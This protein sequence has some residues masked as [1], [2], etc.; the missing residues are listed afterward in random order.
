[1]ALDNVLSGSGIFIASS[2]FTGCGGQ[3]APPPL[4]GADHIIKMHWIIVL[5]NKIMIY[6]YFSHFIGG[7]IWL[8]H[9]VGN[10]NKNLNTVI[11]EKCCSYLSITIF[12]Q[13]MDRLLSTLIT[14]RVCYLVTLKYVFS[15]LICLLP[16]GVAANEN[17]QN[18]ARF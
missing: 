15:K 13:N 8:P 18:F 10:W 11:Y 4:Q 16:R 12:N 14:K 1:M 7:A 3:I 17:A 6:N 5:L 2:K 9:P